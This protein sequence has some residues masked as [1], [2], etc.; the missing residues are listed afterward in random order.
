[1]ENFDCKVLK[2]PISQV[3][4]L[5]DKIFCAYRT[6]TMNTVSS[7]RKW[8]LVAII[9]AAGILI[10]F[11]LLRLGFFDG[12]EQTPPVVEVPTTPEQD[13]VAPNVDSLDDLVEFTAGRPIPEP[14][15]EKKYAKA[16]TDHVRG[17]PDATYSIVEFSAFS[18]FYS[19]LMHPRLAEL[20][21]NDTDVNWIFRH[22][23]LTTNDIDYPLA[24]ASECVF[25][26]AGDTGFWAFVDDVS[27]SEPQTQ[28]DIV[29]AATRHGATGD[30]SGCIQSEDTVN[31]IRGVKL[32]AQADG[33][34]STIP[35]FL[36]IN[37]TTGE[38]RY[39]QGADSIEFVQ[40]TLD[41][42]RG[43]Q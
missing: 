4:S 29:A 20:V 31:E 43:V 37:N 40:L 35:S 5:C 2:R 24:A 30:V 34:F 3:V 28:E 32:R 23:P 11:S 16:S 21:A 19:N 26:D 36:F 10:Y 6:R 38:V 1:M 42:M 17:N 9:L 22:Y 8:A 39:M 33:Q 7:Q 14:T 41:E 27:L 15:T 25:K 12:G 13:V 18:N